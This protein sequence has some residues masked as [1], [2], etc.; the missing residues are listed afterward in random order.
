MHSLRARRY[1]GFWRSDALIK[2]HQCLFISFL[3]EKQMGGRWIRHRGGPERHSHCK[4]R[5]IKEA[6]TQSD[7]QQETADPYQ[8]TSTTRGNRAETKSVLRNASGFVNLVFTSKMFF[9]FPLEQQ[10]LACPVS[11]VKQATER[12]S[13]SVFEQQRQ[14]EISNKETQCL[15]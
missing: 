12:Q 4:R 15:V 5:R 11:R 7:T 6:G 10:L 8:I 13:P 9:I 2:T 14:M 1:Y 3:P